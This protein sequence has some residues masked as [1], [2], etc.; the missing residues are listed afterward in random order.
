MSE[1]HSLARRPMPGEKASVPEGKD[2][3]LIDVVAIEKPRAWERQA[4]ETATAFQWFVEFY[5]PQTT[6]RGVTEAYRRWRHKKGLNEAQLAAIRQP[7]GSWKQWAYGTDEKGHPIPGRLTWAQ[8]AAA[9]DQHLFAISMRDEEELWRGRRR[10]IREMEFAE[11]TRLMQRAERMHAAIL[12]ERQEF[13]FVQVGEQRVPQ[14][15]IYKPGG[16]GEREIANA[17]KVA[18]EL[19]RRA[20]DMPVNLV[21]DDWRKELLRQFPQLDPDEVHGVFVNAFAE[22]LSS[23]T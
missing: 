11:G 9:W 20:A 23:R 22:Y 2:D 5:L 18:S 6:P 14:T 3:E 17:T 10:Q 19:L 13:G 21:Q 12:F 7:P 16:W 8:R 4:W 1:V 15:I